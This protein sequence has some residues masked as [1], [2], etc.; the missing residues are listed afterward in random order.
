MIIEILF[1]ILGIVVGWFLGWLVDYELLEVLRRE[2][3]NLRDWLY[4]TRKGQ[5][6]LKK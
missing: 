4:Y 1:L 3:K 6:A 5:D 2:K